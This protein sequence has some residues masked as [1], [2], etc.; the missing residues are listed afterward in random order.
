LVVVEEKY[1][2]SGAGV[3]KVTELIMTSRE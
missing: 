2:G 3:V 1:E